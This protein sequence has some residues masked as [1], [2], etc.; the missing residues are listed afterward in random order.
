MPSARRRS[1]SRR[2]EAARARRRFATFAQLMSSTSM[3]AASSSSSGCANRPRSS[4][5]ALAC[6]GQPYRRTFDLATRIGGRAA[7]EQPARAQRETSIVSRRLG[8]RNGDALLQ[9]ADDAQ[10]R[11]PGTVQQIAA[12]AR[13][14][15]TSSAAPTDP[16]PLRPLLQRN[17]LAAT[18]TIVMGTP[19]TRTTASD[20]GSDRAQ[21]GAANID[22]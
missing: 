19:L 4:R 6:R 18:P 7:A 16:A 11:C 8:L 5:H 14:A 21:D 20:D 9:P 10:P 1:I 13:P 15:P 17:R 3:T 2:R 12:Q 22:S